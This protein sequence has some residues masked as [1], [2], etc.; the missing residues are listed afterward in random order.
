MAVV[1]GDMLGSGIF[2]TP[3]TLAKVADEN[4]QVYFIWTLCG[5][6]VLCGALTLGELV[7]FLP[8]AGAGYHIIREAFGPGLGFV[9]AWIEAWVSAP[10]SMASIAIVF[11][12]L[13]TDFL[14]RGSPRAFGIAAIVLFA[15]INLLGVR[16]GGR[17]LVALTAVKIA[18]L[19]ALV[20]G[21]Y[22][23][24]ER[25]IAAPVVAGPDGD[26]GILSFLRF[27][28]L[29]VAAVLFTYDGWTDV[30]HLAG[31]VRE[32]GKT[33]PRGLPLGVLG[34]TALCVV[35]NDAFLRVMP[36]EILRQEGESVGAALAVATFGGSGGRIVSALIL[37]SIFGS[38]GGLVMTAPRLVYT[39]GSAYEAETRGRRGHRLFALLAAVSP[40]TAVPSGAIL[41]CALLATVAILFFGTFERLVAFIVV[42]LQLTN[43]LMVA[44]VFRLRSSTGGGYRTPG[45]PWVPLVFVVVMSLLIGNA[46][47][48]NPRD[49]LMG[50][51]LTALALPVYGWI[52][53]EPARD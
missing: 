7:S 50:A 34:I 43:I 52:R 10:G 26:A 38:L 20:L 2:F 1:M 40:R 32:P 44:A 19:L 41:F 5:L 27:V 47:A 53:K 11:G 28:G 12:E 3:G 14:G 45:Y 46:I 4:W 25:A 16:W 35:V 17:T 39:A 49:T 6:I 31:E 21:S 13:A 8:R 33:L 15:A 24:A 51:V 42:P 36:L 30:S 22:L 37:I 23:V 29:G 18:G 9:K 48:F